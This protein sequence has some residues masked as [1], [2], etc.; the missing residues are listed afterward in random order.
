VRERA[1]PE[2]NIWGMESPQPKPVAAAHTDPGKGAEGLLPVPRFRDLRVIGQLAD[3]YVL[4]EGRGEL[5]I[6]DQHAAHERVT[7]HRLRRD[8]RATLG[9]GQRLL[10]PVLIDLPLARARVLAPQVEALE[11]WGLEVRAMGGATF[12]VQAVPG[13]LKDA[14]LAALLTDIADEVAEGGAPQAAGERL[15]HFLATLACHTSV[16]A[17]QGLSALEMERL[18]RALDEV[19]FSV[20]AHGR[21]VAIRIGP[22]ELERRFHRS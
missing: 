2:V 8:A 5:V 1:E 9:G 10:T 17:G 3:T 14:D 20:C 15:D 19:D 11:A 6:V 22:G 16:R 21:P 18:L 12:A 7:L 4:C 13:P